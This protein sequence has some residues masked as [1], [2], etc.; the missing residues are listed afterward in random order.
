MR[1]LPQRVTA[2]LRAKLAEGALR[3][4]VGGQRELPLLAHLLQSADG[5]LVGTRADLRHL[6]NYAK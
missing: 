2:D 6:Y 3:L 1:P 5:V 4:A